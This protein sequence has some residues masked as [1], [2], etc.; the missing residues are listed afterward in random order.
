MDKPREFWILEID[1]N[2]PGCYGHS[3]ELKEDQS[4]AD[5]DANWYIKNGDDV[6]IVH[7][8]EYSAYLAVCKERDSAV[9]E[10]ERLQEHYDQVQMLK[11]FNKQFQEERDKLRAELAQIKKQEES[12]FKQRNE[13]QADLAV[14]VEALEFINESNSFYSTKQ[15]DVAGEALDKI[16]GYKC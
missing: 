4:D 3:S 2:A 9:K 10:I 7:V 13:L 8:I 12:F 15:C 16:K 14:A 11:V 1:H 6:E 5:T